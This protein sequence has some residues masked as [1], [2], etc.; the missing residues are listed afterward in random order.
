MVFPA[1]LVVAPTVLPTAL[2]VL[3]TVDVVVLTTPPTVL[4]TPP[5]KPPLLLR[6]VLVR[7]LEDDWLVVSDSKRSLFDACVFDRVWVIERMLAVIG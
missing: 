2:V 7:V 5:S 6:W 4:P 3:P 1:A